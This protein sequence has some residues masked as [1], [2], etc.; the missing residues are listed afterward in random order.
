VKVI[1]ASYASHHSRDLPYAAGYSVA[2]GMLYEEALKGV[3]LY[4]AEVW[5]VADQ[6]GS[7]DVGKTANVVVAT[8]DPL[9]VKTDVK[10]IFI[11]GQEVST[12]SRQSRLRDEYSK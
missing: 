7:L 9:D 5:G 3:T 4:P 1:F 2:F 11:Q 6:L 8:G 12:A 10:R